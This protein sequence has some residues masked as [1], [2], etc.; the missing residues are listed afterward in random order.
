M[1]EPRGSVGARHSDVGS[2]ERTVVAGN[3]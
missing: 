2:R 1:R 3:V